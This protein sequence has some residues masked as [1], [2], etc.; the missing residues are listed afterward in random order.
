MSNVFNSTRPPWMYDYVNVQESMGMKPSTSHVKN[1]QAARFFKRQLLQRAMSP[2]QFTVPDNWDKDY[3]LY[4]LYC[5]GFI[6]VI[7]TDKFGVIP[8]QCSLR[9]YNVFYHPREIVVTN[10][11]LMY[12]DNLEIGR[13]CEVINLEPDWCGVMD[14]V[15]YYGDLLALSYEALEMNIANSKLAYAF[16]ASNKNVA[17][18]FKKMFDDIQDGDLMVAFDK[19]IMGDLTTEKPWDAIFND[20]SKNYIALEIIETMRDI[21]NMFDTEIGIANNTVAK[22]RERV[23]TAEVNANNEETFTKVDLWYETVTD[24]LN[25]VNDMFYGGADECRV[26]WRREVITNAESDLDITGTDQSRADLA[27]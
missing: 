5:W 10:P 12:K 18:T 24:C 2:F 8:Q 13:N 25:R 16:A 9:G 1:N 11:L 6:G 17:A 27:G 14:L 15:E 23:N 7:N 4:V 19:D 21:N 20:L 26:E 22:K 3:F